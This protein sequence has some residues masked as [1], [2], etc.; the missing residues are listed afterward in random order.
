MKE[1]RQGYTLIPL[2]KEALM[3]AGIPISVWT[4]KDWRKS[5]RN[6]EIFTKIGRRVFLVKERW[7]RLVEKGIGF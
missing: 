7:N 6:P 5:G 3:E 1:K 2:K 4:L